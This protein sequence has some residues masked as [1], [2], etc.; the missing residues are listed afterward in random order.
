[1]TYTS[2]LFPALTGWEA[3]KE[4]LHL[5][6][7][8]IGTVPRA[9]ATPHPKWWH[10]SL[11]VDGNGLRTDNMTLADGAT[12]YLQ[13]DLN[14]HTVDVVTSRGQGESWPMTAGLSATKMGDNVLTA[15][16]DLGLQGEYAR[17]KF[18]EST[19]RAYNPEAARAYLTAVT[20]A[21]RIFSAHRAT[22]A[23][24]IGPVQLWPHGFD[25]AFEWFGT[26]MVEYEEEGKVESYPSQINWGFSP[27]EPAHERRE[28]DPTPYFYA[29]P[30]PF[31]AESLLATALPSGAYW[32]TDSWQGSILPYAELV[33]DP[34]A[35]SRLIGYAQAVYSAAAPTLMA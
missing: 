32:F 18:E 33:D 29:N 19:V 9:H 7:K 24:E 2:T 28:C 12:F 10:I 30:F 6:S 31:E 27:G 25:L 34:N 35:E 16:A 11:S 15:I 17:D 20:N 8:V 22:L 1:M 4:T 21:N 5:Y 13:L 14:R 23:G 3:T 26:R